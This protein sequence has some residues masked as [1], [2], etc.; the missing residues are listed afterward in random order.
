MQKKPWKKRSSWC[1]VTLIF[2]AV[3]LCGV[4]VTAEETIPIGH[5]GAATEAYQQQVLDKLNP[6]AKMETGVPPG[7]DP[8]YWNALIPKDNEMTP[9]RIALGRKLYFD[10]RLSIDGTVSCATCHD[11]TRG[12]SDQIPVAEGVGFGRRNSPTTMNITLLHNMFWDGRSPTVEHQAMQPIIN[13]VEMGMPNEEEKIIAGIKDDPEYKKLFRDAYDAEVNYQDIGR[14]LACFERT[15]NFLDSPFR[16]YLN[17]DKTAISQDALEGWKLFNREGRCM[18]CHTMSP[19]NP[20]GTD[21]KFHNIGVA[22]RHQNFS[23]LT[24]GALKILAEDNSEQKLDE[25]ALTTDYTELGRF[26]FSLNTNDIGAFRTPMLVNVGIT[27]PYMHDGSFQT[28]WDVLD[29]YNKGGEPNLYLDGGIEPLNLTEKQ[30][31]QIVAFLFSL[32][33]VRFAKENKKM[34]QQQKALAEKSRNERKEEVAQRKVLSFEEYTHTQKE[35]ETV[36]E[37]DKK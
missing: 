30:I 1:Y 34:Y 11:V 25:L 2:C 29:H 10:T 15:L 7:V 20:L 35:S 33:D 32:T 4:M 16:R 22:A 27:G 28:L 17:G 9:A 3:T 36:V 37:G 5:H 6:E 14:A 13:E 8:V 21:S 18:T 19:S 12:F 23:E 31:D 24:R 26:M